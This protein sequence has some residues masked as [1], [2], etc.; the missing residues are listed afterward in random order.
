ML[1]LLCCTGALATGELNGLFTINASGDKVQFSQGNLQWSGTNGWRFASNQWDI[2]GSKANNTSPT[3]S[4]ES[5]LDLFCW[6]L[7]G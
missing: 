3:S 2:I 4:N 5:Y 6:A 7:R 1:T